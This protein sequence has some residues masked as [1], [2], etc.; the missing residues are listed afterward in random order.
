MYQSTSITKL[1]CQPS[2]NNRKI[3]LFLN[4]G[5]YLSPRRVTIKTYEQV[6]VNSEVY[7]AKTDITIKDGTFDCSFIGD[8]SILK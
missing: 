1:S 8:F 2:Q 6:R 7:P 3:A 5:F 4:Y